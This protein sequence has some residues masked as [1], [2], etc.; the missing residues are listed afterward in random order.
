MSVAVARSSVALSCLVELLVMQLLIANIIS[1]AI[2]SGVPFLVALRIP[3]TVALGIS[4]FVALLVPGAVPLGL[5][6]TPSVCL[7]LAALCH[8]S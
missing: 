5:V 2:A 1:F 7:A 3:D 8:G 4:R 6:W